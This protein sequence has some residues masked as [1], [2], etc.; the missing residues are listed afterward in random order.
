MAEVAQTKPVADAQRQQLVAT[1][2][3]I[4]RGLGTIAICLLP[5]IKRHHGQFLCKV[6][7]P[8]IKP[9]CFVKQ[10]SKSITAVH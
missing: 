4:Q 2:H 7:N 8:L 6:R 1:I 3:S 9:S 5:A 10:A